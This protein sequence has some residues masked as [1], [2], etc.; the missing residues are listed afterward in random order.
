[1][2]RERKNQIEQRAADFLARTYADDASEADWLALEAWL[3]ADADHRAAY[4]RA[5]ALWAEVG[6][7]REEITP[8]LT[9]GPSNVV[10]M[11]PRPDRR[12]FVYWG[13]AAAAAVAIVVV[14]AGG[15]GVFGDRPETQVYATRAGETREIVLS[16]GSRLALNGASR[17]EVRMSRRERHV[18][19]D[20]AE[21]TF[22]VAHDAGRPFL[23]AVGDRQVRVVG[24]EF[25][26]GRH[27][28]QT[29][30]TVR[31][32][33]VEVRREGA[34]G[35]PARLTAG[36]QLAAADGRPDAAVKAVNP[37]EAFAWRSGRLVYSD[38]PMTE[39]AADL[40]RRFPTPVKVDAGANNLRF[41]G[42]LV[43]DDETSV[44]RRLEGLAPVKAERM[45]STII[46]RRV[47]N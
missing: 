41:T 16:D 17:L 28:G 6:D 36:K 33:V 29:V 35:P 26:I 12:Q 22:D 23:I 24:T 43:L 40:S 3:V 18:V 21:V 20:D 15:F 31:R 9:S 13:T 19:M 45:G 14:G 27:A 42:V 7:L 4:D 11:P 39:V 8:S 38:R 25:N 37:E 46:L 30:V 32:G 10:A 34:A 2:T 47:P 1:M 44:L 5:E